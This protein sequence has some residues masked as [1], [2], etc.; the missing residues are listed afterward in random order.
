MVYSVNISNSPSPHPPPDQ[1]TPPIIPIKNGTSILTQ[2]RGREELLSIGEN[3][4]TESSPYNKLYVS[5]DGTHNYVDVG[6][7]H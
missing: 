7:I 2:Q 4:T 3:W 5:R 1:Q 6:P